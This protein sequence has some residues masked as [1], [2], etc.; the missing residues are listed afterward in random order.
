M[1]TRLP[2]TPTPPKHFDAHKS[3]HTRNYSD[4]DRSP[5]PIIPEQKV[6]LTD[7]HHHD[8]GSIS[9]E[10]NSREGSDYHH[11]PRRDIT[12]EKSPENN[13]VIDEENPD[14]QPLDDYGYGSKKGK[15]VQKKTPKRR[16]TR[17]QR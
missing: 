6:T 11:Y 1:D 12:P 16:E 3:Y 14:D 15:G 4:I 5:N 7:Y 9:T 13:A 8:T 10:R 2:Q 17:R